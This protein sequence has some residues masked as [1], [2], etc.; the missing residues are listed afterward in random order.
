MNFEIVKSTSA[1]L[2]KQQQYHFALTQFDFYIGNTSKIDTEI[3]MLAKEV[4]KDKFDIKHFYSNLKNTKK[5]KE[6]LIN[7]A[8]E[9]IK[10]DMRT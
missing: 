5:L 2:N 4:I 6:A 10:N 1:I 9:S 3:D 8:F 7:K